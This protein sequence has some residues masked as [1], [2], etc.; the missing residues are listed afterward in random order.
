[1]TSSPR[2]GNAGPDRIGLADRTDFAARSRC[3]RCATWRHGG[4]SFTTAVSRRCATH[5]ASTAG[6]PVIG[7]RRAPS[8]I[9]GGAGDRRRCDAGRIRTRATAHPSAT[10]ATSGPPA[11]SGR[12]RRPASSPKPQKKSRAHGAADRAA[13]VLREHQALQR[14][15]RQRVRRREEDRRAQ[16]NR[17]RIDGERALARAAARRA[18]RTARRFAPPSVPGAGGGTSRKNT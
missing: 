12:P 7:P 18:S 15:R 14:S 4:C 17:A 2:P 10:A 3:R 9:R 1:M 8:R 13:G 11:A 16:R 5:F 6:A